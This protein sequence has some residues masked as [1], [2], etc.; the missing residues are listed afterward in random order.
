MMNFETLM[1]SM[2]NKVVVMTATD[3]NEMIA[4]A[5]YDGYKQGIIDAG[6][7]YKKVVEE[8]RNQAYKKSIK[9]I[10]NSY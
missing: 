3:L 8:E 6:K 5:R 7:Q 9:M 10:L 2:K 1:H 4:K